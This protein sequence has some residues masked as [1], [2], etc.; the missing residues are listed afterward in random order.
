M[1]CPSTVP[2]CA[3]PPLI[4]AEPDAAPVP[5]LP[6]LDPVPRLFPAIDYSGLAQ[7]IAH[8]DPPRFALSVGVSRRQNAIDLVG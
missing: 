7:A 6:A 4:V 8:A 5:P 1:S 2:A 3:R